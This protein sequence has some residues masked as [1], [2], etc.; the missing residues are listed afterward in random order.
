MNGRRPDGC[1]AP[2][3]VCIWGLHMNFTGRILPGLIGAAVCIL[4]PAVTAACLLLLGFADTGV[5]APKAS[6]V[7]V[8]AHSGRLDRKQLQVRFDA[9]DYSLASVRAGSDVPRLYMSVLPHDLDRAGSSG[10]RKLSF[11]RVMLPL[12]LAEN[13]KILADRHRLQQLAQRVRGG[14]VL[15]A[16][17]SAW[18]V[19]VADDYGIA[20]FN[21]DSSSWKA[22]LRRVDAVP[23]SLALAQAIV[24]SGWGTSRFAQLGNAVFGQLTWDAGNGMATARRQKS[25]TLHKV[26]SFAGLSQSVHAYLRNLNTHKHYDGFRQRRAEVRAQ[27]GK[28]DSMDL[29]HYLERYSVNGKKYVTDV[30]QVIRVNALWQLDEARLRPPSHP[31]LPSL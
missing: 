28:P 18:A 9:L 30:R 19:Q 15:S 24:E 8:P 7:S 1:G 13:E 31:R 14:G 12:V 16:A 21:P 26:R 6:A 5:P 23:V 27:A 3:Q 17:D 29:A 10:A 25:G 22:L 4:A 2:Q 11:L 20:D